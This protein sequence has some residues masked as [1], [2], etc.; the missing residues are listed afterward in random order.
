[1]LKVYVGFDSTNYGQKLAYD[2]CKRSIE[3]LNSD[4]E[5]IKVVKKDLVDKKL[6]W[7]EDKTGVTEFTYTR[8]LV[9]YLN[10]YN[11]W[12]LFCDSDF[13]WTCDVKEVFDKYARDEYAVCCVKHNYT[14]C[15]GKTKMDGRP[16]EY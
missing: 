14:N 13:L 10:E 5:V 2:V 9:P 7:R 3:S 11:G 1:M 4:I 15:N 6:F 8:F 16:Q 12:A